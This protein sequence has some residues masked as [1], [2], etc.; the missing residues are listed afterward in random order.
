M[1]KTFRLGLVGLVLTISVV[2]AWAQENG[3]IPESFVFVVDGTARFDDAFTPTFVRDVDD[4]TVQFTFR[5]S[6]SDIDLIMQLNANSQEDPSIATSGIPFTCQRVD[7]PVI[8]VNIIEDCSTLTIPAAASGKLETIVQLTFFTGNLPGS[9]T[10]S[11]A[12][13]LQLLATF[14]GRTDAVIPIGAGEKLVFNLSP[15]PPSV[16]I[17]GPVTL[18]PPLPRQGDIV[19]ASFIVANNKASTVPF[20]LTFELRQL[21]GAD[22]LAMDFL[23]VDS[24]C[25]RCVVS[26]TLRGNERQR[27]EFKFITS[28]LIPTFDPLDATEVTVTD[29]ETVFGNGGNGDNGTAVTVSG[30]VEALTQ[31]DDDVFVLLDQGSQG[32]IWI[33]I[34]GP[35]LD[36]NK[37]PIQPE[38]I[39]TGMILTATLAENLLFEGAP[40]GRFDPAEELINPYL[41]RITANP[42]Q[43]N[44][45]NQIVVGF[46]LREPIRQLT[47]NAPASLAT[48]FLGDVV[49]FNFSVFNDSA[50]FLKDNFVEAELVKLDE[51]GDPSA[52]LP[53]D[54]ARCALQPLN[55]QLVGL[56]QVCNLIV[57]DLSPFQTTDFQLSL[58]TTDFEPGRYLFRFRAGPTGTSEQTAQT[59]G[60]LNQATTSFRLEVLPNEMQNGNGNNDGTGGPVRGPELRPTELKIVPSATVEQGRTLVLLTTIKNNGNLAAENIEV[61][62]SLIEENDNGNGFS[63]EFGQFFPRLGIGLTVEARQAFETTEL[64]PGRYR[65][66]VEVRLQDDSN[67]IELDPGNNVLEAIINVVEKPSTNEP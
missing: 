7:G 62:F 40:L 45:I 3:P 47:I 8:D 56:T 14:S 48:A 37:T 5:N 27:V 41:L 54:A 28:A 15:S 44:T 25:I 29:A 50:L 38:A 67:T 43:T 24:N 52:L 21:G 49:S 11:G 57:F 65:V 32:R 55:G 31:F 19:T 42:E 46:N 59:L 35:V 18:D 22:F 36:S 12:F 9:S 2:L 39:R 58:D 51:A 66:R 53:L 13:E 23:R 64:A 33:R 6:G 26:G 16:S 10:A 63:T 30:T 60:L 17:E 4:I 34:A 61:V 20:R 1:N